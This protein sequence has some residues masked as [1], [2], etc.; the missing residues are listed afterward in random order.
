MQDA[1]LNG[2]TTETVRAGVSYALTKQ[3][4]IGVR[5]DKVTGD[6]KQNVVAVN[7]TRSF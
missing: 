1:A 4:A 2:D 6:A 7:Y 3:D 5:Y